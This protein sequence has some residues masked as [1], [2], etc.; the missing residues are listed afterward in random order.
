MFSVRCDLRAVTGAA[1]PGDTVGWAPGSHA[2]DLPVTPQLCLG[3]SFIGRDLLRP[4]SHLVMRHATDPR[5]VGSDGASSLLTHGRPPTFL[6][7]DTGLFP[8]WGD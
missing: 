7:V 1:A 2:S 8:V 6:S 5:A 4:T 3:F